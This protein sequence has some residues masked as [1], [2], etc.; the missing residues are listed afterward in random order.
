MLEVCDIAVRLLPVDLVPTSILLLRTKVLIDLGDLTQA[1]AA[2]IKVNIN[3]TKDNG[4]SSSALLVKA[5]LCIHIGKVC[6]FIICDTPLLL[7]GS[8]CRYYINDATSL[9]ST[10]F[11]CLQHTSTI[12]FQ[13]NFHGFV[14]W[15]NVCKVVICERR[16]LF[17]S[18]Y[19][20]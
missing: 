14:S 16:I 6:S 7:A 1:S 5:K 19:Y 2:L 18:I 10:Q 9:Q 13:F 15:S 20:L 11:Y 3:C 12:Q 17:G 8:T 4:D